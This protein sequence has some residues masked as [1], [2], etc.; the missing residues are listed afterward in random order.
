MGME[1]PAVERVVGVRATAGNR[2]TRLV[3]GRGPIQVTVDDLAIE[4][5]AE[6][7]AHHRIR[8]D[9]IARIRFGVYG[10]EAVFPVVRIW[11][12]NDQRRFLLR[13]EADSKEFGPFAKAAYERI[14]R[15][16]PQ[17]IVETGWTPTW[18]VVIAASI[19]ALAIVLARTPISRSVW[20]FVV[21]ATLG[22]LLAFALFRWVLPRK[23]SDVS[24][25]T[26]GI[27]K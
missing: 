7:G 8:L 3:L 12:V 11:G 20:G 14:K 4:L 15:A 18:A 9:Q 26:R 23:V 10:A 21:L 24:D 6:G 22:V 5:A 19:V 17:T 27:P 13:A 25:L 1:M 2:A 16:R